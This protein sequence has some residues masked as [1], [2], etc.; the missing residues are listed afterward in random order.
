VTPK[1]ALQGNKQQEWTVS[2]CLPSVV[3]SFAFSSF[4]RPWLE[5]K[6]P[7]T[8]L[9]VSMGGMPWDLISGQFANTPN[10]D[11]VA[12]NGLSQSQIHQDGCSR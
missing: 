2:W 4:L 12:K 9:L 7:Q 3:F 1:S 10:L 5:I 8:V 6:K 11:R